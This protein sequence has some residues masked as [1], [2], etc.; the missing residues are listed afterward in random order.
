MI[1]L[2]PGKASSIPLRPNVSLSFL[3]LYH[4]SMPA[5]R[6]GGV[7]NES[8]PFHLAFWLPTRGILSSPFLQ[9]PRRPRSITGLNHLSQFVHPK[10]LGLFKAYSSFFPASPWLLHVPRSKGEGQ[11]EAQLSHSLDIQ[12]LIL[13]QTFVHRRWLIPPLFSDMRFFGQNRKI[14][15]EF[16]LNSLGIVST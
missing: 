6:I 4:S 2:P 8:H 12:S 5:F 16:T 13:P 9:A 1:D 3:G 14:E 11:G 7:E 15:E 10:K